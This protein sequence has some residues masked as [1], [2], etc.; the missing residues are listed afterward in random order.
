MDFAVTDGCRRRMR[1]YLSS[2]NEKSPLTR[3]ID[4]QS[5]HQRIKSCALHAESGRGALRPADHPTGFL[6][7]AQDVFPFS[8]STR[9]K[10]LCR[11]G[12]GRRQQFGER[13][14]ELLIARENN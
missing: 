14:L 13:R 10:T 6:E 11:D 7:G 2:G 4:A 12:A 5:F 8:I 9:L 1:A 3:T